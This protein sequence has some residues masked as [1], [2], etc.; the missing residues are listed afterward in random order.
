M[1][2][3]TDINLP[4]S[5]VLPRVSASY[6]QE[7]FIPTDIQLLHSLVL[8]R[9]SASY[10]QEGFIPTDIQLLHSLVLPRASAS[11]IQEGF[12]PTDIQLLH[13]LV[14]PRVS[15]S[16]IQEGFIP[17]DIQLLHSLVLPR[18]SARGVVIQLF[19][20]VLTQIS[21]TASRRVSTRLKGLRRCWAEARELFLG[22]AVFP[23][24]EPGATREN[25]RFEYPQG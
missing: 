25:V 17:T 21:L 19:H 3:T 18:A 10:I 14:L 20:R 8:P 13:S 7:G 22:K 6:I 23:R 9:A 12:I 16:Y 1:N 2:G 4:L 11:Y 5:L 15:A 24:L